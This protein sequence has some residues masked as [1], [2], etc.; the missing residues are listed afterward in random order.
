MNRPGLD[1]NVTRLTIEYMATIS[2]RGGIGAAAMVLGDKDRLAAKWREAQQFGEQA[3]AAV[4]A[5]PDNPY[6]TDDE[7]IAGELLRRIKEKKG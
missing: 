4:K 3:L 6:G 7:A 2:S 5:A 1:S